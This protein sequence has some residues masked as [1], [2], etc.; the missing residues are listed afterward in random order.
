[1]RANVLETERA[2]LALEGAKVLGTK[3]IVFSGGGEPL[4]HPDISDIVRQAQEMRFHTALITNGTMLHRLGDEALSGFSWVRVSINSGRRL[5]EKIHGADLY[6]RAI[7]NTYRLKDFP[8]VR[9]GV[10]SVWGS[11][12]EIEDV[13]SLVKDLEGAGLNY[14]RLVPD[15]CTNM[16]KPVR[17]IPTELF[18]AKVDDLNILVEPDRCVQV[19]RKC[20]TC[21]YKPVLEADGNLYPCPQN[22]KAMCSIESMVEFWNRQRDLID[23]EACQFCFSADVNEFMSQREESLE[24]DDLCF[25]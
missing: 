9:R 21:W 6:D 13:L 10:N 18:S 7:D 1:M 22:R 8:L 25:L 11:D 19:P 5:Y 15:R 24:A 12:S 3:A 14:F 20:W 16:G 23:T 17:E 2:F 4:V